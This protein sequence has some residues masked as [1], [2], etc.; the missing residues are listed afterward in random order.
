MNFTSKFISY[1]DSHENPTLI[2]FISIKGQT[3]SGTLLCLIY[4]KVVWMSLQIL[5]ILCSI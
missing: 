1:K 4:L 2:I 3:D 5:R